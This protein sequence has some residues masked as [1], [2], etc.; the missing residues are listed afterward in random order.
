MRS[1]PESQPCA[2]HL[3]NFHPTRKSKILKLSNYP[4]VY[5]RR[6]EQDTTS[7]RLVRVLYKV[8]STS[9]LTFCVVNTVVTV[10]GFPACIYGKSMQ[11][12]PVPQNLTVLFNIASLS[13]KCFGSGTGSGGL[14]DPEVKK[15][16][17]MLNN[18]DIILFFSDYYNI[19]SF[20]WLLLMIQTYNN[21]VM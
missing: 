6:T 14:L 16:S 5:H 4:M 3:I 1:G 18:H 11:V 19:L 9:L 2:R 13:K 8:L 15:R 17:K 7:F 10:V 12:S 20:N 21:E